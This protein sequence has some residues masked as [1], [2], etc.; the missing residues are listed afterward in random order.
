MIIRLVVLLLL[1][2]GSLMAGSLAIRT[3]HLIDPWKGTIAENQIILVSD[4]KITQ[5]GA[6]L[7]IPPADSVI[8]LTGSWV[9]PG[10]IDAHSH[11]TL[12]DEGAVSLESQY[13]KESSAFRAIKG[14]RNAEIL[15][16]AGFTSVRDLGNDAHYVASDLRRVIELGWY[17]GPTVVNSGKIITPFGGQSHGIP[18]EIGSFWQYEYVDADTPDEI[19]KA[20]RR[21]IFYGATVIKLAADNSAYV[22]SEDEIRAAVVE[23]HG[24]GLKVAVHAMTDK[25]ARNA[26]LAGADS[27]EHGFQLSDD[28]L[29]LMKEKGTF[30]VGTDFPLEH[31]Q[32]V[33][34]VGGIFPAPEVAGA[35]IVSRLTRAHR[36]GV[37]M[38]FG[39]DIFMDSPPKSRADLMFEYLGVW[40][41]AGIP[42]AKILKC[43][44][45]N[46][47]ELLGFEGTRGA[48]APGQWADIIATPQNP[49][50]DI[51]AL[52]NV[53]FV[54]K[55]GKVV[56]H[57]K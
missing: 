49:L 36:I 11:L 51:S 7:P 8:D 43:M 31:L 22:Y 21:N 23:A 4:G 1:F 28:V 3:G 29:H 16:N 15:L 17:P 52:S 30:L 38:A 25:P 42:A 40:E 32:I 47:A 48:I 39:T 50:E 12:G 55:N 34:T 24:A 56:R 46:A 14:L 44:T 41:R 2:G 45:T 53:D 54:M 19:R 13:L 9:M 27:I 6:D 26:I 33:G 20:V 10:L 57:R 37:K 35:A 18:P 5:V